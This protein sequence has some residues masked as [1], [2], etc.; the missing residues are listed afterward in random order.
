MLLLTVIFLDVPFLWYRG[1]RFYFCF[2]YY[3]MSM[4]FFLYLYVLYY[5]LKNI[6]SFII[7]LFLELVHLFHSFLLWSGYFVP[8]TSFGLTLVHSCLH[9]VHGW[10]AHLSFLHSGFRHLLLCILVLGCFVCAEEVL[11]C[12]SI[13][14]CLKTH[15][16]S[17]FNFFTDTSVL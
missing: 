14:N 1:K 6:V 13:I 10:I 4:L 3:S 7:W 15:L 9:K 2:W 11:C 12:V 8:F 16:F 17:P 5:L